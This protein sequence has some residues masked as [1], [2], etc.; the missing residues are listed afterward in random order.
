MS[1]LQTAGATIRQ[2]GVYDE[3]SVERRML[4]ETLAGGVLFHNGEV[5]LQ[6]A[7]RLRPDDAID[8]DTRYV[9]LQGAHG[10]LRP[11]SVH[12]VHGD[13]LDRE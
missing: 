4:D 9:P 7:P 2:P 11:L 6:D 13:R 5:G 12:A 3:G 1:A 8:G 10:V